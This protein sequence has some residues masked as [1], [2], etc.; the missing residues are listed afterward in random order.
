MRQLMA[1]LCDLYGGRRTVVGE[2]LSCDVGQSDEIVG[3]ASKCSHV[4]TSPPY[5][6]AQD[7]FRNSKLELY[8]LEE[9]LP[10]QVDEIKPRFI[11]SERGLDKS[12]TE[13]ANADY[14][15]RLIPQLKYLERKQSSLAVIVHTYLQRMATAFKSI[16]KAMEPGGTLVIVCGDNL[17][18]G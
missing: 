6:N 9:I 16:K 2:V 4:I 12:I 7:Y 13:S 8:L 14:H 18:G 3:I 17:I 11:G 1:D 5:I 15:R 10:F